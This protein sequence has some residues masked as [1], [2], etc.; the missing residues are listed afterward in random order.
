MYRDQLSDAASMT[1]NNITC[2]A[3]AVF[4]VQRGSALQAN[5]QVTGLAEE[6]ELLSRVE[7]AEDRTAETTTRLQ[8]LKTLNRVSRSSL[9]PSADRSENRWRNMKMFPLFV[10][11]WG[12]VNLV[13]AQ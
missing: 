11:P 1:I 10:P 3:A 4:T 2:G 6:P 9:L 7:G 8:L 5:R 12:N 13:A